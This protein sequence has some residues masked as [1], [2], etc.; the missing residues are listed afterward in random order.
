MPKDWAQFHTD[1]SHIAVIPSLNVLYCITRKVASRQL[2]KML[3]SFLFRQ[4]GKFLSN[5]SP[6][7]QKQK[8]ETYFKFAFVR[9]PFERIL[10][11]YKDKFVY[12]RFPPK[13]LQLHGRAILRTVRPNASQS[14]L[15]KLDDITFREFIEY[16]VTK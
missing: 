5:L 14:A 16:L 7:E 1:P 9:E 2:R 11:A 6:A 15:D 4:R 3:Y 12:P 10:S 13:K 8:L